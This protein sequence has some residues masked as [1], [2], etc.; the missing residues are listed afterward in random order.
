MP[1]PSV[2]MA[3]GLLLIYHEAPGSGDTTQEDPSVP[4]SLAALRHWVLWEAADDQTLFRGV[5][6]LH[7]HA[8]GLGGAV[9]WRK[10][11][12]GFIFHCCLF[13]AGRACPSLVNGQPADGEARKLDPSDSSGGPAPPAPLRAHHH[14]S[15]QSPGLCPEG[16]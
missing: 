8:G 11:R 3:P 10:R 6:I 2:F 1:Q 9:L 7:G 16:H 14:C 13:L 5:S 12:G 15:P 4:D